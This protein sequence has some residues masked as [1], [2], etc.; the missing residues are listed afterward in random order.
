MFRSVILC[1]AIFA[2]SISAT[3]VRRCTKNRP[4][5]LS[6][7]IEGCD[8]MPCEAIKGNVAVMT[9]TFVG[10]HDGIKAITTQ[11]KASVVGLTVPYILPEDVANVCA[12]LMD[13]ATCPI[14]EGDVVTYS[15]K[16][17][18][19]HSE[20]ELSVKME[21]SF[22]EDETSESIAC[23]VVDIKVKKSDIDDDSLYET[24]II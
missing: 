5:P 16:F 20:P 14:N 24:N 7:I 6:V 19:D 15:F 1:F 21:T 4:F 11:A 18:I 9:A 3:N 12:N 22:V 2:V 17:P 8:I 10:T 13:G 23:F